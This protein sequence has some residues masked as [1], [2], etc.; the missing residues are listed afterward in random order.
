MNKL[1]RIFSVFLLSLGTAQVSV[2]AQTLDI[3]QIVKK[4][5]HAVLY[6]GDDGKAKIDM[7]IIDGKGR[8]RNRQLT[9]IRKNLDDVDGAQKYY[10][11]FSKPADIKKMVFM[12]WKNLERED[13]RWLYLP[14]L[15]LV[16]RIAASD[17][18]TSFVGSHF[19]YED[20]S[21][22][23]INED[24]HELLE[25][26]EQHYVTK[27]IPK[28]PNLV[29]F[30]Y[31]KTWVDKQT[32]LPIKAEYFNEKDIIYR[33]YSVLDIQTIDSFAT[34][35]QAQ[36]EDN[37]SGGKTVLNYSSVK[38]NNDI[39]EKIF[40]ERYLRRAPKKYLR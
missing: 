5:N 15:D 23:D 32:F 26:T 18:R 9:M 28:T 38:Y 8:E 13:D 31:Y 27:S 7:K 10:V 2:Q 29:E 30:K 33:T 34:V 11:Y 39:P 14:A 4:A 37:I 21:G 22:R 25:E 12:T 24:T 35:T 40:S 6:Q 17:E 1:N 16:K 19:F 20:V 3:T 36:I